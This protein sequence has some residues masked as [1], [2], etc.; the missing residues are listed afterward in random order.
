MS[1]AVNPFAP[2]ATVN[3]PV[4]PGMPVDPDRL[5]GVETGLRLV[6]Y[7]IVTILLCVIAMIPSIAILPPAVLLFAGGIFLGWL[8][9]LIGPFFCLTAPAETGAS[10]LI[11]GSISCQLMG[12]LA[13]V[14]RIFLEAPLS[15]LVN[16]FGSLIGLAGTALFLLF[17][18]KV[19]SHVGRYDL[20][21]RGRNILIG[22][23][24]M[25]ALMIAVGVGAA[26]AGPA[27]GVFMIAAVIGGI[28]LF[29][30]YASLLHGLYK[31]IA[32]LRDATTFPANPAL[33]PHG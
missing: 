6:Y 14:V 1:D 26:V 10:G 33:R 22:G 11:I 9:M 5:A 17:L 3:E 7:G 13:S 25:F 2:P 32:A 20:Q 23:C 28:V 19:A 16:F 18:M 21:Q 27:I 4:V 12:F 8:M 29:V 30:M 24:I 15:Q 31:A